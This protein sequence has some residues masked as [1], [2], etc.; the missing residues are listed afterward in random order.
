[1]TFL[2]TSLNASADEWSALTDFS[3]GTLPNPSVFL[4]STN[5]CHELWCWQTFLFSPSVETCNVTF[6][7]NCWLAMSLI[8]FLMCTR[9][10][11]TRKPSC[12]WQIRA[13]PA[14]SLHGL[15]KSSGVVVSC[16]A[17]LLID[18]VPMVYYYFLYSNCVCKKRCFGDTRLLKLPWHWNAGQGSLKVI[19]SVT[20]R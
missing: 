19:E 8:G 14:K 3:R 11:K 2:H 20:I 6:R 16:I 9:I 7:T 1:V 10:V 13:T 5:N 4:S 17:S 18:S 15:R 12:R